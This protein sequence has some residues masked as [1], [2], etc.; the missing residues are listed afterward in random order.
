MAKKNKTIK[1]EL[2]IKSIKD[3]SKY[4]P[5]DD[6]VKEIR[7]IVFKDEEGAISLTITREKGNHP[8]ESLRKLLDI[9]TTALLELTMGENPQKTLDDI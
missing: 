3:E 1:C 9:G 6:E 4:F 5:K 7:S 2:E 8:L